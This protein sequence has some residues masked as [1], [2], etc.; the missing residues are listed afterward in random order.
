MNAAL[1]ATLIARKTAL[2]YRHAVLSQALSSANALMLAYLMTGPLGIAS[3]PIWAAVAVGVAIVRV[4]TALRYR[5]D[6]RRVERAPVWCRRYES[7]ALVSGLVWGSASA[8]FIAGQGDS[9]RLFTA[10]VVA[11]TV[12]GAVPILAPVRRAFA[13]FAVPAV[14]PV[15]IAAMVGSGTLLHTMLAVMAVLFLIA[16]LRS[17]AVLH[18][19]L[20]DAL[21]LELGKDEMLAHLQE[22]RLQAE[23]ASLAKSRFLANMSHEIRTPMNGVLGMAELLSMGTLDVEQQRQLGT[24]RASGESLLALINDVLDLSKIESG[25]LS[26]T[27]E[28]MAVPDVLRLALAPVSPAALGKGLAMRCQ[29]DEAIPAVVLGDALRLRQ[30]LTNLVG[31]A[32]KFTD[33]GEVTVTAHVRPSPRG[34]IAVTFAVQDT[35][36]GIDADKQREIFEDFSQADNSITRRYGGTG[37]GLAISR[38]LVALMGGELDVESEIGR[39]SRFHFTL[40]FSLPPA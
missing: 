34:S 38:R 31:N 22:A 1:E 37:L 20:D 14:V 40:S 15:A 4:A 32:V 10:F 39:G 36:I 7:G 26:L 5:A 11:G 16:M 27:D 19:T 6:P 35:G 18:A 23:A 12:A 13:F 9:A 17:A 25:R 21:R 28:P 30:V 33:R 29:I 8:L 3:A 2:I 24:L